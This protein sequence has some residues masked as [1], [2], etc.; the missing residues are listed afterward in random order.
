M[1][2]ALRAS[3]QSEE[4]SAPKRLGFDEKFAKAERVMEAL[5]PRPEEEP[6]TDRPA[7]QSERA[8]PTA[9]RDT[10]SMPAEEYARI[11]ELR[12]AL[13]SVGVEATR[14]QVARAALQLLAE[15]RDTNPE[16]FVERVAAVARLKPGPKP[17]NH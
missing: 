13:L 3:V 7:Q 2:A 17:R 14:S 15:L 4:T 16:A 8:V 5:H 11:G 9:K 12:A 1:G 6:A 10:F